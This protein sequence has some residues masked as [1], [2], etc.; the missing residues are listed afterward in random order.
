[1]LSQYIFH[2]QSTPIFF[3]IY[4]FIKLLHISVVNVFY[5]VS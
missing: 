3:K 1:M 5:D 4:Q 2:V